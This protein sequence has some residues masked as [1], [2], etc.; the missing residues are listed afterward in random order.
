MFGRIHPGRV[1]DFETTLDG[2]VEAY[3][4]M[5]ERRA[6]KSLIRMTPV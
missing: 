6:I 2:K 3:K 5:N 4:A 1:F